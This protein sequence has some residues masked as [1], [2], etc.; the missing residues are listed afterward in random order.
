MSKCIIRYSV[1]TFFSVFFLFTLPAFSSS[2]RENE[3]D[4]KRIEAYLN[5][6]TTLV[7]DFTQVAPDGSLTGGK[8]FLKRPGKMRWQ[9]DPPTPVLMVASGSQLTY[10]DYELEQISHIP[11]DSTL[12]SFL[13]RESI[14]LSDNFVTISDFQKTP[15]ML[16]LTL[17][18]ASK[19]EAGHLT[20]TFSDA[21]LQ[22][23]NMEVMDSQGQ[24]TTV[25]LNNAQFGIPL[26]NKLFIFETPRRRSAKH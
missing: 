2:A 6:I 17:S 19:P 26:D 5:G 4:L 23:R 3:E 18:Q 24:S 11:I 7:S 13:A 1:F 8:F 12:A 15:G 16:R 14:S 10:Y 25:A 22:L 20:L 21:P 9:Y